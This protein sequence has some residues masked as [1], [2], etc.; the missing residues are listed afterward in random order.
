[1]LH[2]YGREGEEAETLATA[3]S[4]EH[5]I[6]IITLDGYAFNTE[7][8]KKI[9]AYSK[10]ILVCID[11]DQ[12][13]HYVSDVVIN[14]AG[15]VDPAVISRESFTKLFVGYEYLLLRK[16]FIEWLSKEKKISGIQSILICFGG[17]DPQDFTSKM[18]EC[19]SEDKNIRRITVVVGSGYANRE[20][21]EKSVKGLTHIKLKSDLDAASLAALMRE[22]DLAI[23]PSSTV[24][25]EAFATGMVLLAGVT[26][27]NQQNI[28]NGLIK[29]PSVIGIG[30]FGHVT[31]KTLLNG[32][33]EA[34]SKYADY[35]V[36]PRGKGRDALVEIYRSLI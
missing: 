16:D 14:H 29:E 18:V 24:S 26:A 2:E 33:T 8:Q 22:T 36:K 20:T 1:L 31:C 6:D 15:G 34:S 7:Y 5:K 23:V 13:F 21:L 12:P 30:D 28:Y 9:K 35:K 27:P 10:C 11:D 4:T 17:V 19:L 25:L 3:I 32:I